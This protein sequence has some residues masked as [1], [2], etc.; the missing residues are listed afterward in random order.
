MNCCTYECNQGHDC[1]ARANQPPHDATQ[2]AHGC[3]AE[4]GNVWFAEPEPI[5][6]GAWESA[7][8]YAL[9]ALFAALNFAVI[10]GVIGYFSWL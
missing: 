6:L 4:G 8:A 2:D 1:P 10:A 3:A 5:P 7:G 9:M